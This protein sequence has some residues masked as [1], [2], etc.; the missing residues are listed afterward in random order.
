MSIKNHD[1]STTL[2]V[3][4]VTA[5]SSFTRAPEGH[6]VTTITESYIEPET[7][8]KR[9]KFTLQVAEGDCAGYKIFGGSIFLDGALKK[10][11]QPIDPGMIRKFQ[12]TFLE[13]MGYQPAQLD[14]QAFAVPT[15]R[16]LLNKRCCIYFKP[17]DR[18]LGTWNEVKFLTPTDWQSQKASFKSAPTSAI[19]AATPT[20]TTS[21]PTTIPTNGGGIPA[22]TAGLAEPDVSQAALMNLLNAGQ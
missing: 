7:N 15:G 18:D 16:Q 10:N 22:P 6:Y 9:V 3:Q 19:G 17:G 5:A 21:A 13:S 8:D 12:R 14:S 4:G 2:N 1:W 11:G 20:V